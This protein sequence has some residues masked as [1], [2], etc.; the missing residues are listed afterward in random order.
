MLAHY[1]G[2]GQVHFKAAYPMKIIFITLQLPSCKQAG[3]DKKSG[4]LTGRT[5]V[6]L[7]IQTVQGAVATT[8]WGRSG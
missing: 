2:G 3:Q 8:T 4:W 7:R 5:K 1:S 6:K